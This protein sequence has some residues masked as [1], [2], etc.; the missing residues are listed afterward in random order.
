M[1]GG[2][3]G[4]VLLEQNYCTGHLET[5]YDTA[6]EKRR[7]GRSRTWLLF[8]NWLWEASWTRSLN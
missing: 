7:E 5:R 1:G 4:G 2:G 8:T 3:G 6:L